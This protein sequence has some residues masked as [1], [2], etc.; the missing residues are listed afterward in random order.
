VIAAAKHLATLPWIDPA[1]IYLG[2]H[3]TGGTLVLLTAALSDQFR[4]VFSFGPVHN[5][6]SYGPPY[7]PKTASAL[8]I[9]LRSPMDWLDNISSPTFV[10]EGADDGNWDAIKSMQPKDLRVM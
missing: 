3:S 6:S 10:I 2:G 4:A 7:F 1:R 5:P 9:K 8:E